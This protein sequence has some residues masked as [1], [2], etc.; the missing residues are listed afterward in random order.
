MSAWRQEALGWCGTPG[1]GMN[2]KRQP[3][4]N[5][6][7]GLCWFSILI[8]GNSGCKGPQ[9]VIWLPAELDGCAKCSLSRAQCP[10]TLLQT[11]WKP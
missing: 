8:E 11:P 6:A 7:G 10:F 5:R 9:E 2:A 1:N 3:G 4:R